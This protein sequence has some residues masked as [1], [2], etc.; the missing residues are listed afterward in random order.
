MVC[1]IL[2]VLYIHPLRYLSDPTDPM[3]SLRLHPIMTPTPFGVATPGLETNGLDIYTWRKPTNTGLLLNSNA[4]CPDKLKS[5]LILCLLHRAKL[6]SSL[7]LLFNREI[8]NLKKMF[9]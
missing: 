6:I 8:N 7:K 3:T 1:Q 4:V 9:C 2:D 5:G